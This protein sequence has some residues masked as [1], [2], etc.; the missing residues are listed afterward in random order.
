MARKTYMTK[1]MTKDKNGFG[2]YSIT[3]AVD[4][5]NNFVDVETGV[6]QKKASITAQQIYNRLKKGKQLI[7]FGYEEADIFCPPLDGYSLY[8]YK[9]FEEWAKVHLDPLRKQNI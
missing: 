1:L 4:F 7:T 9:D 2:V 5:L 8:I 6:K 3:Y